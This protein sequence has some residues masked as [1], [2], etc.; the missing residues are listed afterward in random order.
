MALWTLG[1]TRKFKKYNNGNGNVGYVN[2]IRG[3]KQNEE[4]AHLIAQENKVVLEECLKRSAPASFDVA[5]PSLPA[6]EGPHWNT[7]GTTELPDV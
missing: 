2:A 4:L 6:S 3:K 5:Y 1:R 7:S